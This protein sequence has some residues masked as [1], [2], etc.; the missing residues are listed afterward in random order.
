MR[1]KL[2][3]SDSG[4]PFWSAVPK[5]VHQSKPYLVVIQFRYPRSSI[6]GISPKSSELTELWLIE[7]CTYLVM[8]SCWV[9]ELNN[10]K[11]K[12]VLSWF[13]GGLV[14]S[15]VLPCRC[16]VLG[17][18]WGCPEGVCRPCSTGEPRQLAWG[19]SWGQAAWWTKLLPVQWA[20]VRPL[21]AGQSPQDCPH[22]VPQSQYTG[23]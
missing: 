13:S 2:T 19:G 5:R 12:R 22:L 18:S 3:V 9:S 4:S 16:G 1:L 15:W 20:W 14:M 8:L 11:K 10:N 17:E 23:Y 6:P 7:I 21:A